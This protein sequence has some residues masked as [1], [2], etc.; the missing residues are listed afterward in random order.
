MSLSRKRIASG[1]ANG[2][3]ADMS[4]S[5]MAGGVVDPD[6]LP[7]TVKGDNSAGGCVQHHFQFI[8]DLRNLCGASALSAAMRRRVRSL[9]RPSTPNS[10]SNPPPM[11]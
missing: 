7:G 2:V 9:F 5:N 3:S 11:A 6:D 10:V 4:P 1:Q 8:P